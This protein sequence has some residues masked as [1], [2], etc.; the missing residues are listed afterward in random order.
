M[1][2]FEGI[3]EDQF[4]SLVSDAMDWIYD[5]ETSPSIIRKLVDEHGLDLD[6]AQFIDKTARQLFTD[7][8]VS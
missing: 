7:H 6:T 1:Y 5:K 8:V 4:I 2:R 3:T